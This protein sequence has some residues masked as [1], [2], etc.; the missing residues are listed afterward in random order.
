MS[1]NT[2]TESLEITTVTT[3]STPVV[4]PSVPTAT[5]TQEEDELC[6]EIDVQK[7]WDRLYALKNRIMLFIAEL[8][9]RYRLLPPPFLR[10]MVGGQVE[11][12][13]AK[14]EYSKAVSTAANNECMLGVFNSG[15]GLPVHAR[16]FIATYS[17]WILTRDEYD[18]LNSIER[19]KMGCLYGIEA[20]ALKTFVT[21]NWDNNWTMRGKRWIGWC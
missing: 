16:E 2:R 11:W 21:A 9:R 1:S 6:L 10:G 3:L 7:K 4:L 5:I 15:A 17:G 8:E 12:K 19:E 14:I 20:N 13:H 18:E